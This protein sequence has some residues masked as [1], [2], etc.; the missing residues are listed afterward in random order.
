MATKLDEYNLA[1]LP[2]ERIEEIIGKCKI[3]LENLLTPINQEYK[4]NV[5]R[6]ANWSMMPSENILNVLTKLDLK[7]TLPCINGV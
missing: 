2:I 4:C 7:L 3:F 6:A 5:F 1:E